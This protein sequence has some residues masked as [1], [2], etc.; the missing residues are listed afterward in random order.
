MSIFDID[1]ELNV[2]D[3]EEVIENFPIDVVLL[4]VK[5]DVSPLSY[6]CSLSN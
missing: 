6:R 1:D 3:E 5:F 2:D 4:P